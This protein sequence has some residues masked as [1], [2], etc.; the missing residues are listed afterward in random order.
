[1]RLLLSGACRPSCRLGSGTCPHPQLREPSLGNFT[2]R[3]NAKTPTPSAGEFSLLTSGGISARFHGFRSPKRKGGEQLVNYRNQGLSWLEAEE[4]K[5]AGTYMC[6]HAGRLVPPSDMD[7]K[8][9]NPGCPH[10]HRLRSSGSSASS[11]SSHLAA[12]GLL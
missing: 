1:M 2:P 11:C 4:T 7:V 12:S 8:R 9:P 10:C 3:Q 5:H 6:E